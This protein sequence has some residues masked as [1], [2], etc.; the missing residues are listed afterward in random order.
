MIKPDGVQRALVGP[1]VQKFE[2]RGFKLV[3]AKLCQPGK[4]MFEKHYADLKKKPFFKDLVVYAASGPVYCMV[5]EGDNVVLTGRKLLGATKP[6]DSNP[7]TI[8]GNLCIDVGRN[9]CHGSDSVE[10]ANKEIALWFKPEE[11]PSW[12]SHSYSWTYEVPIKEL[13]SANKSIV[14][15]KAA[16]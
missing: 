14:N 10:S 2:Q 12:D 5:W 1:I 3:A 15:P 9:I 7:G 16:V 4:K 8:R 11:L 13:T 6:K